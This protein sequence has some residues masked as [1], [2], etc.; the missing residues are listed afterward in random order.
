M[1]LPERNVVGAQ[2]RP[3]QL[4]RN[5]R[6]IRPRLGSWFVNLICRLVNNT[7]AGRQPRDTTQAERLQ[8]SGLGCMAQYS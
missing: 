8:M 1:L 2:K 7:S 3:V 6:R 4:D 5:R